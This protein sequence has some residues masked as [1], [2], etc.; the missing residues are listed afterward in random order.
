MK[1][2]RCP[3]EDGRALSASSTETLYARHVL[4]HDCLGARE[5][6]SAF[7]SD[8]KPHQTRGGGGAPYAALLASMISFTPEARPRHCPSRSIARAGSSTAIGAGSALRFATANAE[9]PL[10]AAWHL[11]M[12]GAGS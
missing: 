3:G 4:A 7:D 2:S 1:N 12:G 9:P 8:R 5:R 10:S 6:E 11:R